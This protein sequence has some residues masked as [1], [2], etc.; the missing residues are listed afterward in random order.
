MPTPISLVPNLGH[1]LR[2]AIHGEI[3]TGSVARKSRLKRNLSEN[4]DKKTKLIK[5]P[6]RKQYEQ[7]PLASKKQFARLAT[8]H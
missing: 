8:G 2:M 4:K 6:T 1:A 3:I 5:E 7:I